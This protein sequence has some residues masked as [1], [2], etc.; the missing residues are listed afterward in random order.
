MI[1]KYLELFYPCKE[2]FNYSI[3]GNCLGHNLLYH[4]M[5]FW[6]SYRK[7]S[8]DPHSEAELTKCL[9]WIKFCRDGDL[10]LISDVKTWYQQTIP[11]WKNWKPPWLVNCISFQYHKQTVACKLAGQLARDSNQ[12]YYYCYNYC[13]RKKFW[14]PRGKILTTWKQPGCWKTIQLSRIE[15]KL[16]TDA[17]IYS[18]SAFR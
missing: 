12:R 9:M 10:K 11:K 15:I 8:N 3:L 13:Y 4:L 7:F 18:D 16:Y 6:Y 5:S 14:C 17:T 1:L 2:A